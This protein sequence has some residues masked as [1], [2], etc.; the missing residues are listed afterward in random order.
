MDLLQHF[1]IRGIIREDAAASTN[2]DGTEH[3]SLLSKAVQNLRQVSLEK[4]PLSLNL[5]VSQEREPKLRRLSSIILRVQDHWGHSRECDGSGSGR[6]SLEDRVQDVMIS[7][8]SII[9]Q[10]ICLWRI[11]QMMI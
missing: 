11:V 9:S 3:Q 2:E 6:K 1:T 4:S 7:L 5:Q 10:N 8:C